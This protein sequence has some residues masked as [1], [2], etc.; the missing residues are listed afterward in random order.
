[1]DGILSHMNINHYTD[2]NA[3]IPI[4]KTKN[5]TDCNIYIGNKCPSPNK[6]PHYKKFMCSGLKSFHSSNTESP[7]TSCHFCEF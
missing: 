7:A 5:N 1:M 6:A 4:L 3:G 2:L